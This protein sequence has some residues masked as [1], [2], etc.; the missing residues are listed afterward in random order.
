MSMVSQLITVATEAGCFVAYA[1]SGTL[2]HEATST[3]AELAVR[4]AAAGVHRLQLVDV[5]SAQRLQPGTWRV[6]F[7]HG[8]L[9]Q[10]ASR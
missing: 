8:A 10:E 9:V 4:L 1:R 7:R 6:T 3:S 2:E 5:A